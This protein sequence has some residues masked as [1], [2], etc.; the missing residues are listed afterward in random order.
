MNL[1]TFEYLLALERERSFVRA[2]DRCGVSQPALS[3]QIKKLEEELGVKLLERNNRGVLFTPC[4]QE[5]LQRATKA[6]AQVSEIK[7]LAALWHDPYT[8]Q[9]SIGAIPTLAPYYFPQISDH[10]LE[11]YPQ[12]SVNLVEEK[13]ESLL[14]ALW[15]GRV[16]AGFLALPIDDTGLECA[17][18]FVEPFLVGVSKK[19]PLAR[20]KTISPEELSREDLLLLAEG[21]C[22]QGQALDYCSRVGIDSVLDFR[23]TSMG[24]LLEMIRMGRGI[25]LI[26]ECVAR[27]TPSLHYLRLTGGGA[28][29]S[30]AM[31]WRKTSVRHILMLELVD[32]L[33]R[34]HQP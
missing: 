5:V 11:S 17:T 22:L 1:R 3:I 33:I 12:L 8:G 30:V 34:D 32:D 15:E 18:I 21:H 23:A 19:H 9:I 16:D 7:D 28:K 31:V 27:R 26:P 4:G 2:A 25:S 20:R 13:T 6:L 29:R 10:L 24:T 14:A